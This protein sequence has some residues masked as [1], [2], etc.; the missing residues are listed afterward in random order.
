M[1]VPPFVHLTPFKS[2]QWV[3]VCWGSLRNVETLQELYWILN[4]FVIENLTKSMTKLFG[5]VLL[6]LFGKPSTSKNAMEVITSLL[7]LSC[8]R[9]WIW[10]SFV[11]E[12][13]LKTT[14]ANFNENWIFTLRRCIV[15][16]FNCSI[17]ILSIHSKLSLY[18]QKGEAT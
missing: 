6:M 10:I 11:I 13:Q 18:M 5:N 15:C 7:D 9:Y 2:P 8:E 4:N 3:E 17:L 12:I 1:K 14:S 16:L